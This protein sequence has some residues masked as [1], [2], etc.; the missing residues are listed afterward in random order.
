[1]QGVVSIEAGDTF[2]VQVRIRYDNGR[3]AAAEVVIRTGGAS[4]KPYG[5]MWWRDGF[6]ALSNLGPG[7]MPPPR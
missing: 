7:L 4:D 3:Q 2:R 1:M 5:V 6:E